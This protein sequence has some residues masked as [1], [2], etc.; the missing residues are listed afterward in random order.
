MPV[1]PME[2]KKRFKKAKSVYKYTNL[3]VV[4]E[5]LGH[6]L[7]KARADCYKDLIT[8]GPSTKLI[9][10][11]EKK[12]IIF[13]TYNSVVEHG[14]D[15]FKQKGLNPVGIYQKTS[16]TRDVIFNKFRQED[17]INP[18]MASI[19]MMATGVTLIEANTVIFA[20]TPFR[21]TDYEQAYFRCYR[22][23]QDT[24]VNI[25]TLTLDTGSEPNVS[26]RIEDISNWSK[27]LFIRIMGEDISKDIASDELTG[28]ESIIFS[29]DEKD[30]WL[31][32]FEVF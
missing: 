9:N 1:L 16:N 23:G 32:G 24:K 7:P 22:Y 6:I 30:L 12:T 11:A 27:D 2:L 8:Y 10:E 21:Y 5:A 14:L 4:G 15:F 13:T 25:Y 18:L 19:Q 3:V 29:D 17:T 28:N 26:T 31:S 20:P